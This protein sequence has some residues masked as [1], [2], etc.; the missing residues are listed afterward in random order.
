MSS[1]EKNARKAADLKARKLRPW[2]EAGIYG[3]VCDNCGFRLP[4]DYARLKEEMKYKVS[5]CFGLTHPSFSE[6]P[7]DLRLQ[8]LF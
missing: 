8:T 2:I 3:T 1:L 5:V 4:H 7:L 6:E